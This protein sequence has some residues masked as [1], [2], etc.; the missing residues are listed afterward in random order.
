MADANETAGAPSS[1]SS[2]G[3]KNHNKY[4]RDKP[5][6]NPDIDHWKVEEWKPE[7]MNSSMLEESSFA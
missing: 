4:R 2:N 1:S 7:Y 6:D 3:K 5:W